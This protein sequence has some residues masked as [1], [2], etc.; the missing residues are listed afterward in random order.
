MTSIIFKCIKKKKNTLLGLYNV[1]PHA[2]PISKPTQTSANISQWLDF[3]QMD[4]K[5]G[6]DGLA[7]HQGSPSS[8]WARGRIEFPGS[9]HS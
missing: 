8:S 5:H 6:R 4:Q 9:P 3:L 7:I 1:S 2:S